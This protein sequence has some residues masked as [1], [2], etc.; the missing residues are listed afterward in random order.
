[1]YQGRYREAVQVLQEAVELYPNR[2]SLW[3]NLGDAYRGTPGLEAKAR[4]AYEKAIEL[5]SALSAMNPK[6]A[7]THADLALYSAKLNRKQDALAYAAK[8]LRCAPADNEVLLKC[9]EAH[10]LAGERARALELIERLLRAGFPPDRIQKEPELKL[11]RA[12]PRFLKL[13]NPR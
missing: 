8:A 11:L 1:M 5:A 3:R 7:D 6:D 2:H 4:G 13:L 10:E 9:A 12:D